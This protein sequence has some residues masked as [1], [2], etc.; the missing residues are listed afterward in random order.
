M[1]N[2]ELVL[3]EIRP[4][5]V[6]GLGS[7]HAAERFL[8]ALAERV[9]GGLR[10]VGVPTSV[11]TARLATDLGIP[12]AEAHFGGPIDL[13]VD[14]ADEVDPAL[15]LI[16]GYGRAL[17]RE[18]IVA[19]AARR[20]VILIGPEKVAEKRVDILGRRGR[21]PV[22]VVPF[23]LPFVS[24]RL[25]DLGFV[26]ET[27]RDGGNPV[28]T[29]NGNHLLDLKIGPISEPHRLEADLRAIPGVVGTGLFLELTDSVI[30]EEEGRVETLN[31]RSP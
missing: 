26:A 31:R 6:V 16:K 21:L 18:K 30:V 4:G 14:G 9:R 15:N 20:R 17:V 23:A 7:G 24:R 5:M 10:I 29:D 27:L 22:E 2:A 13:S 19:A 1:T 11:A 25:A 3:Q 28:L 12:L 8:A